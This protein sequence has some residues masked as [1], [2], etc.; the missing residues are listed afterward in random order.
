[1]NRC[2]TCKH[3]TASNMGEARSWGECSRLNESTSLVVLDT[4]DHTQFH[5]VDDFGCVEHEEREASA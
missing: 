3:W 1:M 2:K 4:D 5:T